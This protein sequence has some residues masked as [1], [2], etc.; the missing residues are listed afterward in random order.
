MADV[1][2]EAFPI[3]AVEAAG[4]EAGVP[5]V[6]LI[7]EIDISNAEPIGDAIESIVGP[8]AR[9]VVVDL[10][11]LDFMDSAGIAMLLRTAARVDALEIRNPSDVIR[12][13]IECTGLSGI[14]RIAG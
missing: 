14:F 8:N 5:V 12:R 1:A 4:D 2:D 7:G 10:E 3:G 13:I 9:R 11:R 6:R